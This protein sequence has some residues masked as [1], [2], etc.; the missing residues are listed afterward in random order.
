MLHKQKNIIGIKEGSWNTESYI[1]NHKFL[2]K[3]NQNFLVMASGDEHI[4]PCFIF[5]PCKLAIP[6]PALDLG[7]TLVDFI[8]PVLEVRLIE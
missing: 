7:K 3:I 6:A 5:E 1:E 8:A 2:K 4:Y